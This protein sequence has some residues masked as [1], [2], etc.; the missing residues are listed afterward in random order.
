MKYAYP[1]GEGGLWIALTVTDADGKSQ[2]TIRDQGVG[3]D[4]SA[5]KGLVARCRPPRLSLEMRCGLLRV[6]VL[7]KHRAGH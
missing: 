1:D 4:V 2:L 7:V 3:F 6:F 5:S